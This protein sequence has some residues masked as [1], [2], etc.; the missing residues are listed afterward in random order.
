MIKNTSKQ[1]GSTHIVIIVIL[2]VVLIT[3]LGFVFWQNYINT[4]KTDEGESTAIQNSASNED[5]EK[6]SPKIVLISEFNLAVQYGKDMPNISYDIET[7]DMGTRYANLK[8]DLLVGDICAEDEGFIAQIIKNPSD[9]EN[10]ASVVEKITIGEDTYGLVLSGANCASD[11]DLLS[12]F[13]NSL[14]TNFKNT[15]LNQ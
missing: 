14:K 5:I 11:T 15:R 7:T 10:Q 4:Q 9:T 1:T 8:N 3:T 13:Q 2:A 6:T 12:R